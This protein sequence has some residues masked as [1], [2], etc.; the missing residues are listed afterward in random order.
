MRRR[1]DQLFTRTV[2][3]PVGGWIRDQRLARA[4]Q[5]LEAT[6]IPIGAV[7]EA[8]GL[9][10]PHQFNKFIRRACGVSPTALRRGYSGVSS[11]DIHEHP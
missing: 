7:G 11:G 9:G 3:R 8:I 2:G 4:R 6:S 5:L 1:L 10:D